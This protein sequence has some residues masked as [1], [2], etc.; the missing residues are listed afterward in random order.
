MVVPRCVLLGR[1]VPLNEV[2]GEPMLQ[3]APPGEED[4]ISRSG[5]TT[6]ALR[7]QWFNNP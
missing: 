5:S 1:V 2:D 7:S 4:C 6:T 3:D